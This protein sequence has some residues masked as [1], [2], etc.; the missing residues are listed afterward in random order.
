M[1]FTTVFTAVSPWVAGLIASI[2]AV[3]SGFLG[4]LWGSSAAVGTAITAVGAASA[5]SIPALIG[6]IC[7]GIALFFGTKEKK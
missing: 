6:A 5:F 4:W 7:G 3:G 2:T 1:L